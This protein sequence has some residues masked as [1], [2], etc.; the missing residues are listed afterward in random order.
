VPKVKPLPKILVGL[1]IVGALS[2]FGWKAMDK[3][4]AQAPASTEVTR[5]ADVVQAPPPAEPAATPQPPT[6]VDPGLARALEAGR[7]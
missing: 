4:P 7:K 6:A 2:Y 5:P 1:A 3:L